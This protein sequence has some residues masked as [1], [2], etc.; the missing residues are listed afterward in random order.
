MK[1]VIAPDAFKE[2]MTSSEV[3]FRMEKA[4]KKV[5]PFAQTLKRPIADGGEGTVQV[6]LD[7][8]D[9]EKIDVEVTGPLGKP[10]KSY[11]GIISEQIAVIEI[12]A[13]CGLALIPQD[14]RNPM[15]TTSYGV[16]ELIV[17]ALNRGVR[18]FII[19]LGGSGTNDG[20]IG[21]AQG[22]GANITD[23]SGKAVRFGGQGLQ[24]VTAICLENVDSRLKQCK[25]DIASDVSNP[26]LGMNGGT[27]VYGP[28][29]GADNLMV[30][31][32]DQAMAK[33][34][35]VLKRDLGKDVKTPQGAGAAGGIGAA[36]VAFLDAKIQPGIELI[37]SLIKFDTVIKDTQLILTGEGKIDDQ[38]AFGKAITGV[39][40]LGQRYD[41]PVIA[42][43]GA[44]HTKSKAI[45][46][47]GV[48]AVFTLLD[49]PMSLE[50]AIDNGPQLVEQVTENVLRFFNQVY[51][52]R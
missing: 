5:E 44:N 21:M 35:S 19:G 17:D 31:T 51:E 36:C 40:Q 48:T 46:D 26:L 41:I 29:K 42:I 7:A 34:A 39:A 6:L 47:A 2:S 18:E 12:A 23:E 52:K 11:Y 32:L 14:K 50:K 49:K 24:D 9:G 3:A 10:I 45:Y 8:F 4:I 30:E 43:T 1:I 28:Q 37:T 13:V 33:Y 22:L 25:I 27:Y 16:G 20:G 15:Q 38:T